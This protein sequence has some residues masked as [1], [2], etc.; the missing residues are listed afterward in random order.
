MADGHIGLKMW[1]SGEKYKFM[2]SNWNEENDVIGDVKIAISKMKEQKFP[3]R[4]KRIECTKE[5]YN[6]IRSLIWQRLNSYN[7]SI[8][9]WG[10]PF[11]ILFLQTDFLK[12]N[13]EDLK[14]GYR[15]IEE[16]QNG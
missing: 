9:P 6:H 15:I 3:K 1:L 11:E 12:W 2:D 7:E 4:P 14:R 16:E 5:M 8:F 13:K 10:S